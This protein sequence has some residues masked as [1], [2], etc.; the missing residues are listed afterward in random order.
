MKI[1]IKFN[2]FIDFFFKI[3]FITNVSF[4]FV[5]KFYSNLISIIQIFLLDQV[6]VSKTQI[7]VLICLE[8]MLLGKPFKDH[9]NNKKWGIGRRKLKLLRE[10]WIQRV[11][12]VISKCWNVVLSSRI[13]ISSGIFIK[14]FQSKWIKITIIIKL[15]INS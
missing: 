5:I 1:W 9:G 15:K 4:I 3:N 11:I 8:K 7:F 2:F 13:S 12:W 10:E 14:I 6:E